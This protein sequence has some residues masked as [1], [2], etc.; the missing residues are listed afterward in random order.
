MVVLALGMKPN[1]RLM[2]DLKSKVSK[3]HKAGDYKKPGRIRNAIHEAS[4]LAREILTE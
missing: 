3:L 1:K 2:E 4:T